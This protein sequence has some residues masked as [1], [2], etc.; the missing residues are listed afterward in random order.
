MG[1][2][3]RPSALVH[4]STSVKPGLASHTWSR[5]AVYHPIA[6]VLEDRRTPQVKAALRLRVLGGS[7]SN[8]VAPWRLQRGVWRSWRHVRSTAITIVR[9][10]AA[11]ELGD[12]P[13]RFDSECP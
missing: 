9:S 8:S 3:K 13:D 10:G 7:H 4:Y 2:Y 1:S 12:A 6:V 5:L 11:V